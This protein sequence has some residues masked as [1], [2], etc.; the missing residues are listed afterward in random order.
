MPALEQSWASVSGDSYIPFKHFGTG[1]DQ[2]GPGWRML[3]RAHGQIWASGLSVVTH[4]NTG[5]LV[6]VAILR[7]WVNSMGFLKGPWA[8]DSAY[9]PAVNM[10]Q[11]TSTLAKDSPHPFFL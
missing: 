2:Q 7:F 11:S 9:I 1:Y 5:Q 4:L 10:P 3:S 6:A 8:P